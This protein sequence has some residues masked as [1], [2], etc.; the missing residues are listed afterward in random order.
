MGLK[1]DRRTVAV[2]A[3]AEYYG[4]VGGRKTLLAQALAADRIRRWEAVHRA[5]FLREALE[6]RRRLV[7]GACILLVGCLLAACRGI[8]ALVLAATRG[9]P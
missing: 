7:F 9:G 6:R 4:I 1:E 8:A 2:G 5:A 3:V